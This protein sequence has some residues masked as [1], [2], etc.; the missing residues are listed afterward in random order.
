ML[1]TGVV[2]LLGDDV[3]TLLQLTGNADDVVALLQLTGNAASH[4]KKN[5]MLSALSH[6]GVWFACGAAPGWRTEENTGNTLLNVTMPF[7]KM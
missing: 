3:V 5:E 1:E 7:G 6:L 4:K 2:T